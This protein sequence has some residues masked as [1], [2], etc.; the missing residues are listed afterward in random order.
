M[1]DTITLWFP[2]HSDAMRS[3]ISGRLA[4][5]NIQFSDTPHG[6]VFEH[7]GPSPGVDGRSLRLSK[8]ET[9]ALG[10]II[11]ALGVI[12]GHNFNAEQHRGIKIQTPTHTIE[13]HGSRDVDDAI[14]LLKEIEDGSTASPDD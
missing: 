8:S 12:A 3:S 7:E 1:A 13:F 9:V 10:I 14:K 2:T 6:H 11:S 5:A 4:E